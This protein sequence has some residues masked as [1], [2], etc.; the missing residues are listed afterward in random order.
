MKTL[1]I[2]DTLYG[3]TEKIAQAIGGAVEREVKVVKVGE[4]AADEVAAHDFIFVGSPTQGG[5]HTK[6]LQAFLKELPA[7]ALKNKKAAA[8]D[9]RMKSMWV[10]L[11][12]WAANHIADDL[13]EKGADLVAPG[14]GFLVKSGKGP[15]VDGEEERAG[16]W[17]RKV[18]V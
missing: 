15:L 11:F 17:A 3:Y 7:E 1:V 8:F 10:K 14:E 18:M 4:A 12:G 6:A 13:R 5:R 2:Y 16:A 9:T